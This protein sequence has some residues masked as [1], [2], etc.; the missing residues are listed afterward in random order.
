MEIEVYL[1][2]NN[3]DDVYQENKDKAYNNGN[4]S[5]KK[6]RADCSAL[7]VAC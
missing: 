6:V 7:E 3:D 4:N 2:M 1:I 5:E